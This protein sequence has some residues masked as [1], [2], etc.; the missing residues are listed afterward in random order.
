MN[1]RYPL[2]F[3]WKTGA[4]GSYVDRTTE[5][6]PKPGCFHV[7]F[8]P[9]NDIL[10]R[11][12]ILTNVSTL[13]PVFYSKYSETPGVQKEGYI[14]ANVGI[15]TSD[16]LVGQIKEFQTLNID[17]LH[18]TITQSQ[19]ESA[20]KDAQIVKA[21]EGTKG[22]LAEMNEKAKLLQGVKHAGRFQHEEEG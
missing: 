3:D 9:L 20:V 14:Y 18:K 15:E 12:K 11:V 19:I 7:L 10:G 8:I 16:S 6:H 22:A 17:S 13:T 5:G 4:C 1:R 2:F 21:S